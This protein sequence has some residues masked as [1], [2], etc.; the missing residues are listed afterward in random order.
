MHCGVPAAAHFIELFRSAV[1]LTPK[2]FYRVQRF[3]AVLRRLATAGAADLA[4]LATSAGY[5]DQ[6]HLTREFRAFA[7]ITPTQYRPRGTDAVFHHRA[8]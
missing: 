2:H 3:A 7:G 8:G 4:D 5:S 6:A 1:G